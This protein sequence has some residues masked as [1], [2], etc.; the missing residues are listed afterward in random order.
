MTFFLK[1]P[2]KDTG[3]SAPAS[4]T[5]NQGAY[6]VSS[7][8]HLGPPSTSFSLPTIDDARYVGK[9]HPQPQV[10][11]SGQSASSSSTFPPHGQPQENLFNRLSPASQNTIPTIGPG[12]GYTTQ[13]T[14]PDPFF[15]DPLPF[16]QSQWHPNHNT[17]FRP[18]ANTGGP[19]NTPYF[20]PLLPQNSIPQTDGIAGIFPPQGSPGTVVARAF[21]EAFEKL[22]GFPASIISDR[23]PGFLSKLSYSSAYHP[24]TDVHTERVN[25]CLNQYLRLFVH[26]NPRHWPKVLSWAEYFY[27]TTYHTSAGMTPYEAMYGRPSPTLVHHYRSTSSLQAIQADVHDRNQLLKQLKTN[28]LTAQQRIKQLADRSRRDAEFEVGDQVLATH[29]AIH[30]LPPTIRNNQPIHDIL[31]ILDERIVWINQKCVHQELI[32]WKG[33]PPEDRSWENSLTLS[34]QVRSQLRLKL[35]SNSSPLQDSEP[36]FTEKRPSGQTGAMSKGKAESH[37]S[38]GQLLHLRHA[39]QKSDYPDDLYNCAADC[40]LVGRGGIAF[41]AG[42]ISI[43]TGDIAL[44]PSRRENTHPR[45]RNPKAESSVIETSQEPFTARRPAAGLL[46]PCPRLRGRKPTWWSIPAII[47]ERFPGFFLL[48]DKMLQIFAPFDADEEQKREKKKKKKKSKR[49][50]MEKKQKEEETHALSNMQIAHEAAMAKMASDAENEVVAEHLSVEEVADI[51]QMFEKMNINKNGSISLEELKFGL[52]K[53]G[54]QIPDADAQ[55]LMQ[56]ASI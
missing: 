17:G 46:T 34:P 51:K 13:P 25:R 33:L 40:P 50:N 48:P 18:F 35:D 15:Q 4:Q 53:L 22:H 31:T 19:Q 26:E 44:H 10:A 43:D 27:N 24:Q 20:Q 30:H 11:T 36:S 3:H 6:L 47:R 56:A 21:W 41:L 45:G 12:R 5:T 38:C 37:H 2:G 49:W 16:L 1:S 9:S 54:N 8:G 39:N 7:V 29:D 52:H 32:Q 42:T 55:I 23:D 14:V 28:L